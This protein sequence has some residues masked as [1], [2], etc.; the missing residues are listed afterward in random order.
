MLQSEVPGEQ[1]SPT[2]PIPTKP[3]PYSQQGLVEAD[4][5]DYTPAIRDS[6]LAMAQKCRMGPYYI[7]GSPNDGSAQERLRLLVVRP[8]RQRRRQHRRRRGRGPRDGHAVR[9]LADRHEHDRAAEGPV[10]GVSLQLAARQLRLARRAAGAGRLPA[11][12]GPA[13]WRFAGRAGGSLTIGGVSIVKPKEY[14]GV[15]AYDLN[16]GDKKWWIPNGGMVPVKST[17][18]LF[19]GV[20]LPPQG[21]R[22]QAQIIATRTLVIY[23]TGRNGGVAGRPTPAVRGGQGHREAGRGRE[24]PVAHHGD[25]HDL[26]A[27]R[28]AVHRL[29]DGGRLQHVARGAVT[30]GVRAAGDGRFAV[31][32]IATPDRGDASRDRVPRGVRASLLAADRSPAAQG[33]VRTYFLRALGPTSAP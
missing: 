20:T 17:D 7:P 25:T 11:A 3:E 18:P 5:I 13:G 26:H 24:D 19:A 15:T 1:T 21:A 10:L 30:A 8:G 22:G 4:L 23:G 29:R 16:T 12:Q 31:G 9:R 27:P 6:A 2:Q 28:P 14:G 32:R 33:F